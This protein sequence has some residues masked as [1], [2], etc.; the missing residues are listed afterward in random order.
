MRLLISAAVLIAAASSL[1]T[2][3]E[4]T[5]AAPNTVLG[6]TFGAPGCGRID[7]T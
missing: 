6:V 2:A 3:Q 7:R 1:V 5:A 4:K